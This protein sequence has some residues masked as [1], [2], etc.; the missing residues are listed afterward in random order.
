MN[1]TK[2]SVN[3]YN[4]G[5]RTGGCSPRWWAWA[6]RVV[7]EEL[8]PLVDP[9]PG[10]LAPGPAAHPAAVARAI[11]ATLAPARASDDAPPW[12]DTAQA[13]A[14]RVLLH[15][16]RYHGAVLCA[17]PVGSGKTYLALAMAQAFA[18][19]AAVCIVPPALI[20]QW[21]DTARRLGIPVTVW[22]HAQLSRGRLPPGDPA[23]VVVD[24]SH[25]FRHP[26]I[27]RYRTL[28]PWLIGR[29]V[30]LLSATPIVNRPSDLFHQLHLGLRDDALVDDG[31]ISLRA[32][33]DH[34]SVP[35]ALGRFVLQRRVTARVPRCR[36]RDEV[37]R[38]GSIPILAELDALGLS[39]HP[40]VAALIR[41]VLLHAAASSPAALLATL[42]RYHHLLLQAQDAIAAGMMPD[43]RNLRRIIG[44]SQEQLVMWSLLPGGEAQGELRLDDLPALDNL[45]AET[46]RAAD[47]PDPKSSRLAEIL[48][49]HIPTLVFVTARETIT[50]LRRCLP[51][52]WLAWCS[53]R[54]AGIGES[55]MS[56]VDVLRWFRPDAPLH[57]PGLPGR[58]RTLLTTDVT[59][60]G[61]DLQGAGRVVHYDLPWTDVR[62]AQRDGRAVRR[63]SRRAHVDV[64]RFLP[65]PAIEERLHQLQSLT[66]KSAL[67]SRHG[68]GREGRLRWRWRGE[69]AGALVGPRVE[70]VCGVLSPRAGAMAGVVLERDRSP[71]VSA[72]FHCD[73]GSPWVT[74]AEGIHRRLHEAAYGSPC[75]PPSRTEIEGLL[76][77]LAPDIRSL[78]RGASTARIAGLAPRAEIGRAH[79]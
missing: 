50:Y 74:D 26:G 37:V 16:V 29:R 68:L 17:D 6:P 27:R 65:D 35:P 49:H 25:H 40:E 43:R 19:E 23:L 56:R 58:P 11:A 15:A 44:S 79:V 63:G 53:G 48:D 59:A 13:D 12:L 71:A 45:I 8:R 18:G 70:G 1:S 62:L 34:D 4:S 67:P 73:A 64:V 66:R 30:L 77:T 21:R 41:A 10:L 42:R 57:P 22:S 28:A 2:W 69:L 76:A 54:R 46:R 32:A 31:A 36:Y 20:S 33:F 14:F 3:G 51:D 24:E 9:L 78:L 60:E 38:S 61:L 52:R 39:T 47:Q 55:T 7:A 72:V 5:S 75:S